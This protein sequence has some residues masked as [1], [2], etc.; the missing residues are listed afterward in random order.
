MAG[1]RRELSG[2]L[3]RRQDEI[4]A[5]TLRGVVRHARML[6][7]LLILGEGDTPHRLDFAQSQRP[8]GARS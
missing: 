8:V 6:G 1:D 7:G 2:N 4:H 3:R 5:T